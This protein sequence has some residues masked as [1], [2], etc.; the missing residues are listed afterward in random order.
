MDN[1]NLNE[2]P[3]QE[4]P[5]Q[6]TPAQET[7]VEKIKDVEEVNYTYD[8]SSEETAEGS[9]GKGLSIA[10]LIL[11]I[12][13]ILCCLC[14]C[15]NFILALVGL[16]LSIVAKKKGSEGP[17]TGGLI[18]SILGIVL[19]ILVLII[20]VIALIIWIVSNQ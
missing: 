18:T 14:P 15:F 17:S 20:G 10:G 19:S 12:A 13:S 4:T 5:A 8:A 1:N 16:I 7:P 3:V 2:T 11:G 9:S 6:E